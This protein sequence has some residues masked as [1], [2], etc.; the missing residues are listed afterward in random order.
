MFFYSA[1]SRALRRLSIAPQGTETRLGRQIVE[2]IAKQSTPSTVTE[3]EQ[4]SKEQKKDQRKDNSDEQRKVAI[5][6]SSLGNT[7]CYSTSD[8]QIAKKPNKHYYRRPTV[9]IQS[10]GR[11][12]IGGLGVFHFQAP[13]Y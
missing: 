1:Q 6:S 10:D 12:V 3:N 7:L 4:G 2:V 5:R 13:N 8:I 11:I 9:T